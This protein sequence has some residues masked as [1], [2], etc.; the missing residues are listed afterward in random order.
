MVTRIAGIVGMAALVACSNSSSKSTET[1][2]AKMQ[3]ERNDVLGRLDDATQVVT[4]FGEKIPASESG[5]SRCVV[6]IPSMVKGGLIVGG[7]GGKGFA[8]CKTASGW[9]APAPVSIGG[10]SIGAQ[11]GVQSTELLAL[12]KTDKGM[13]SLESGDF[14]VGVDASASAGPVGT[15]R[16]STTD[17]VSYSSSKGLFA[18][19]E[20]NGS[21]IKPDKDAIKALYGSDVDFGGILAGQVAAPADAPAVERFN[22][23]VTSHY[24]KG[25][26][27]TKK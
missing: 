8:T 24:G 2:A 26:T 19:A 16:G 25:H 9:S 10:G 21:T 11:L 6:A 3:S 14:K 27:G 22:S 17:L 20:L 15:G 12:V 1:T 23:A 4:K 7:E 18:G 13:R 5:Q